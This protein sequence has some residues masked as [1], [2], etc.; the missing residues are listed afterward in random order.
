MMNERETEMT[1]LKMLLRENP[2]LL[3]GNEECRHIRDQLNLLDRQWEDA[4]EQ[5]RKELA[6]RRLAGQRA[7]QAQRAYQEPG[8]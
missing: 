3:R 2:E 4:L 5:A 8:R 7:R 1:I 6:R